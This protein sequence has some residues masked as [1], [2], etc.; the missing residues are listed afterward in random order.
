MTFSDLRDVDWI[1]TLKLAGIRGFASALV[2]VVAAAM[3]GMF[4]GP[5]GGGFGSA[6]GFLLFW[7]FGASI[8]GICYIWMLRAISATLGSA[9]GIVVTV[10]TIMQ[11]LV[12]LLVA[13][14]DPLVYFFNRSFPQIL[15]LAD[16][17]LFNLVAVIFVRKHA[18]LA[19]GGE[20]YSDR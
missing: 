18:D 16:F 1:A 3:L 15:D 19:A 13:A 6:I 8:G 2:L 7:T 4:S 5:A 9:V 12:V 14:G 10:C 20:V 11:F 17:K